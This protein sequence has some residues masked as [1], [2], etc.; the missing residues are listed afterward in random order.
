MVLNPNLGRQ[1]GELKSGILSIAAE[2]HLVFYT[3]NDGLILIVRV[4]HGRMDVP[5]YLD[6]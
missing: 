4:L 3:F 2:Q 1:R 5:K 6:L